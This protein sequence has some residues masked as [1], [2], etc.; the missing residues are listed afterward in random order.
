M[1][2]NKKKKEENMI[3]TGY[4]GIGKSTLANKRPDIIDLE[5]S[6]FWKTENGVK[7]RPDDWYVYYCQMAEHLSRRGYIVFVSYHPE[8]REYLENHGT[9]P[10]CAIF[11]VKSIKEDWLKRLYERYRQSMSEKDLMAYEHAKN[12]YDEDID[13]LMYECSYGIEWYTNAM[14]IESIDYDL[15]E[16]VNHLITYV[17][18][19]WMK[20]IRKENEQN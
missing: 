1:C 19:M 3:I 5:S 17:Y 10:F 15:E 4:Q 8:V 16:M 18:D 20:K 2:G 9:E 12:H 11:P 7:T 14:F 13:R 6:C